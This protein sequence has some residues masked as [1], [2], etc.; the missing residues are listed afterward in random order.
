MSG[1]VPDNCPRCGSST[2]SHDVGVGIND[3]N[4]TYIY[5]SCGYILDGVCEEHEDTSN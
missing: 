3:D 4:T 2:S 1:R 5:C